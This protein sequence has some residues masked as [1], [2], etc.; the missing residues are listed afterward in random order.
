MIKYIVAAVTILVLAQP[1]VA[2]QSVSVGGGY[3]TG[4]TYSSDDNAGSE[5]TL[6]FSIEKDNLGVMIL[7]TPDTSMGLAYGKARWELA[8][9]FQPY[10]MGGV[11]VDR[12]GWLLG[13]GVG[14]DLRVNDSWAIV[15]EYSILVGTR[16][17]Y[18]QTT[19]SVKY[20]F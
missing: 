2:E 7:H 19:L 4:H 20:T 13:F 16:R 5:P 12:S 14:S 9:H 11:G 6:R 1:A 3:S 18:K 10:L 17:N 8:D 15:P